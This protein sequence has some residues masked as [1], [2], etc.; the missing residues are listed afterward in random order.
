MRK[1]VPLVRSWLLRGRGGSSACGGADSRCGMG[2]D[3]IRGLGDGLLRS[4]GRLPIVLDERGRLHSVDTGVDCCYST[5]ISSTVGSS[6]SQ[7]SAN[8]TEDTRHP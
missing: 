8:A 7:W 1:C 6:Q 3:G 4:V 2:S 5:P